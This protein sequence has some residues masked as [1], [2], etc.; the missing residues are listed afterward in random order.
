M[1]QAIHDGQPDQALLAYQYL[2]MMPKIAEGSANKVWVVPSEITK[3]LEGLGSAVHE[4]AGIPK[5]SGGPRVRV[6]TD[7]EAARSDEA[8]AQ[9]SSDPRRGAEGDRRGRGSRS[10]DGRRSRSRTAAARRLR[11]T[12]R[13]DP[14]DSTGEAP[15]AQ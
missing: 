15:P 14:A 3:A 13:A 6:D 4:V 1:F 2:Q 10:L 11:P 8:D 9:L 7:P 5:Y 12:T